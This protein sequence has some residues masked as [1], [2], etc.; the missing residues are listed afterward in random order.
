MDYR[1]VPR[2]EE[3]IADGE[4]CKISFS[5]IIRDGKQIVHMTQSRFDYVRRCNFNSA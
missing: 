1:L 2:G 4:F 5:R 3:K